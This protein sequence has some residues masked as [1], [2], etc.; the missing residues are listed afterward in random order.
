MAQEYKFVIVSH[1]FIFVA[2]QELI[3]D[4]F[5]WSHPDLRQGTKINNFKKLGSAETAVPT[6]QLYVC[7]FPPQRRSLPSLLTGFGVAV[8]VAVRVPA[9]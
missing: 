6:M 5:E 7:Y 2:Y 3:A 1:T 8:A 4:F 9:A